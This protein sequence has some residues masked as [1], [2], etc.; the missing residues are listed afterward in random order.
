VVGI[1]VIALA[2]TGAWAGGAMAM[3]NRA[4]ARGFDA[5]QQHEWDDALAAYRTA[6]RYDPRAAEIHALIGD[7]YRIQSSLT[8]DADLQPERQLIARRAIDAYQRALEL[9]RYYSEVMLKMAAACELAGDSARAF[10]WYEQALQVDPN[11]AFN[12]IRLGT[13]Y[14]RQGD[15]PKAIA[16]LEHARKLS[17][18]D[19]T[20]VNVLK[21]IQTGQP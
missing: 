6:L 12:W 4:A 8:T 16:A 13:F 5:A 3:A 15:T 10:R 7:V 1:V 20:A 14:H 2:A 9:N 21:E 18:G 17:P 19:W 11:N